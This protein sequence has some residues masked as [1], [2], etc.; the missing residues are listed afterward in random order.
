MIL[1]ITGLRVT[2]VADE[3]VMCGLVDFVS[4]MA[5]GADGLPVVFVVD[6]W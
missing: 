6:P 1:P 3:S 2:R 4:T 5:D